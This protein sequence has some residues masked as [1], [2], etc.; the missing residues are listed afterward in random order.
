MCVDRTCATKVSILLELNSS[1]YTWS[2][3]QCVNFRKLQK[4]LNHSTLLN[5]LFLVGPSKN[6]PFHMGGLGKSLSKALFMAATLP[7]NF[8]IQYMYIV[9]NMYIVQYMYM[10]IY[11]YMT[12]FVVF[13]SVCGDLLEYYILLQD[14]RSINFFYGSGSEVFIA[15]ILLK[16]CYEKQFHGNVP[17]SG[18]KTG[19]LFGSGFGIVT[20]LE[21]IFSTV[22]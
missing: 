17:G 10:Y 7:T 14:C 5:T 3:Q 15:K 8:S 9:Q 4:G 11:M 18:S 22:F 2:V 21:T 19:R 20:G 13:L 16:Y 6:C 1:K 12:F